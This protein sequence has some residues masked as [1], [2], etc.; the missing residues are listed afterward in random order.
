M[1][2]EELLTML[3]EATFRYFWDYAHPVSGLARERLGS[4]NTVT[5]GGS[6]FGIMAI[7]VGVERGFITR[8]EGVER[9]LK[10]LNFLNDNA[11]RFHGAFSHWLNGA[12]GAV[13][14]FSPNDN[15]GDLVETSFMIQGLLTARQ[16][17]NLENE[18]ENQIRNIITN[19]W[20]TVEWS[21]YKR[22][23]NNPWLYWHW[24]PNYGWVKNHFLWGYNE[25]MI[26]Y[27]LAIASP[28]YS[29]SHNLYYTGW[30][31]INYPPSYENGNSFYDIPLFV[32]S[33]YG[34]PLFFAHYSYLGFDPRNKREK[35]A[36]YF[37]QNRNHAL[38]NRAYCIDNPNGFQGY[39]ENTWGLTACDGPFGY[40]AFSPT[41]DNGTIAPTAALSSFP[42][43]PEE[44]MAAFKNLYTNY[45]KNLWDM[46]GFKDAFNLTQNWFADSY[47]AIDQGPIIVMV[48]NYR[49]GL[50]WENFMA[51]PEIQPMLDSIG[52]V[53]DS[54]TDVN[55]ENIIADEFR[56]I[57]NYPNP[58]NPSTTIMFSLPSVENV[59]LSVYN[60]LGENVTEISGEFEK[61]VNKIY[62]NGRDNFHNTVSSG[63]YFYRLTAGKKT[64][65]GKMILQK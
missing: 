60:S 46:F 57:G 22:F 18:D 45:G 36:N 4:G 8:D 12:T 32:G 47:I 1:N 21:W 31:H 27:L 15:G 20:E 50:L 62:W 52:F 5:S 11:D 7:L 13:I 19:I 39:D 6:G 53:S 33:D 34:G 42:Y 23:P 61:G 30:A 40:N 49:S 48:E 65:T 44:S 59:R 54:T 56:L 2:D 58:F 41:N 29:V 28:T 26:T 55:E 43:T 16:Y 64:L 10:I 14:P 9:L 37:D 51:N 3:Q 24:S 38:I 25:V 17:F 35:Y 63:I